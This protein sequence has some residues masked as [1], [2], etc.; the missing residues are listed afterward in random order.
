VVIASGDAHMNA[1]GQLPIDPR[2]P[3]GPA[4]ATEFLATSISSNGDGAVD[5]RNATRFL[6][7]GNPFL[8][9][10]DNLRGCHTFEVTPREWHTTVKVMDRVQRP[11]GT[12]S[13][14]ARYVLRP[15]S[16]EL[17]QA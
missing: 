7:D 12:L 6:H 13:T 1:I 16:T 17:H 8:R 14:R 11:G 15:D 5:S 3:D 10:A 4:A 2:E 9:M